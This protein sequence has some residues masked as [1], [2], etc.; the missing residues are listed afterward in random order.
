MKTVNVFKSIE[1]ATRS[2]EPFFSQFLAD[3]LRISLEGDRTLFDALW[4]QA[5][6][7]E[8]EPPSNPKLN[9]EYHTGE[10]RRID[11]CIFAHDGPAPRVLG[12]EIKTSSASART[13]Q[14]ETYHEG[15]AKKYGPTNVAIAYLTPFNCQRAGETANALPTVRAFEEFSSTVDHARHLSWLDV[16]DIP[17]DGGPVWRLFRKHIRDDIASDKKLS[18]A[19]LRNRSFDDFFGEEAAMRYWDELALIGVRPSETGAQLDLDRL[20]DD[21]AVLVRALEILV[22]ASRNTRSTR[23][24]DF[25]TE[26]HEPFLNSDWRT[27]HEAVFDMSQR[28]ANVWL[29]GEKNY[30]LRVPHPSR[31]GSSVS[32][33]RSKG[34]AVL[35]TGRPR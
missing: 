8:W 4:R 33:L 11:I 2:P 24:D 12:L 25:R 5:M 9:L 32:L 15:L 14:L 21:P 35:E 27:I 22:H 26:L 1:L 6:P 31:S 19:K 30:A 20:K 3:A 29:K 17:W 13:G 10:H 16:A 18:L 28:F 34:H 23:Q 7:E